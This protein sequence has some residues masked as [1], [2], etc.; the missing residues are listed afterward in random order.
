MVI[1]GR[2]HSEACPDASTQI[3]FR[4]IPSLKRTGANMYLATSL[5]L[6]MEDL[7]VTLRDMEAWVDL[8]FVGCKKKLGNAFWGFALLEFYE[9][10]LAEIS[11]IYIYAI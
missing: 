8:V 1:L 6:N 7:L 9:L 10:M 4:L 5:F 3:L 2:V 11:S